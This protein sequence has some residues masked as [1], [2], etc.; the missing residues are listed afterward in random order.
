MFALLILKPM[1]FMNNRQSI[2]YQICN[3]EIIDNTVDL[4]PTVYQAAYEVLYKGNITQKTNKLISKLQCNDVRMM[5]FVP[6]SLL[7]SL[8]S[9]L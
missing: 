9:I 3:G 6:A 8:K 1:L 7:T 5:G 2:A 4:F